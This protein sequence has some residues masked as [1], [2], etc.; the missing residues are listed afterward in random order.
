MSKSFLLTIVAAC[1]LFSGAGVSAGTETPA[2]KS[3]RADKKLTIRVAPWGPTQADVDAA[4]RRVELS[5]AV[6]RELDGFRFR[7]MNFEYVYDSAEKEQPANPPTRFRITYYNYSTDMTLLAESDF[8]GREKI[9]ITSIYSVPGIGIDEMPA[10]Q[11]LVEQDA[12]FAAWKSSDAIEFYD[13]MPPTTVI[14]GERIVNVGIRNHQTG[15]NQIVGVSFKNGKV[16]K[17]PNNA[18]PTSAA[19][20]DACGVPNAG[21][22]PT[23]QGIPGQFTLTVAETGGATLWEMLIVR[24]S[25]SVGHDFEGSG[26]EVRDVKYRGKSILKR[27]HVPVLNVKYTANCGPYRDWQ[28]SEG[29]FQIPTT[30]VSF[31]GGPDGGFAIVDPPGV[32][33]TVVETGNDNG[34][35]RGVAVYTQDV[36]NGP[37]VVL[38][39]EMEAGWYRYV[40]EWRF[41]A[42][43][44]IRPR[45]GFGSTADSCVCIQRT[46]HVYWRFD[47]DVVTPENNVFL[48]E[49]GRKFLKQVDTESMFFKSTQKNRSFLIQNALGDEAYQLVPGT[50]D[51]AVLDDTG[52]LVDSFGGGDFWLTR[53]QGTAAAPLEIDDPNTTAAANLSPWV[54][55]ESLDAQDVVIWYA[56]H[57]VRSDSSSRSTPASPE[58]IN[59]AHVV[60][61]TLRP[62]RW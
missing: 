45:Y 10:A 9:K 26:L 31:P 37:E 30:G 51:G 29:Y 32:P 44:T 27:G 33:T 50:N 34:N 2:K 19:T 20:P 3:R 61:P 56:A 23:G 6:Q 58:V 53:F 17:Y 5:D 14:D 24:P 59:G 39:T 57:Q 22:A 16:I 25:S 60:G 8:A 15:D 46:H 11:R 54:N 52:N 35:F 41:G 62:V 1:L 40:M 47:F 18:P 43:G 42:D 38:V 36:G 48:L 49:R 12:S 28:Y 13:P 7:L 21:Q 55:G 4:K